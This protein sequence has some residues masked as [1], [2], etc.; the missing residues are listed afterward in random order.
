MLHVITNTQ[1]TIAGFILQGL[2]DK[3][4]NRII[5]FPRGRRTPWQKMI[6][7]IESL[8]KK[9]SKSH[10]LPQDFQQRLELRAEI[11]APAGRHAGLQAPLRVQRCQL[12]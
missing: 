2:V 9:T 6:R 5:E 1:D 4:E 11:L 10:Y 7:H 3:S 12:L 8:Q